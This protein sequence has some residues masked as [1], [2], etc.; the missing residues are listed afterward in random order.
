M[1]NIVISKH[2]ERQMLLRSAGKEEVF[3]T[4]LNGDVQKAKNNKLHSLLKFEFNDYSIVND[5]YYNSKTIDVIFVEEENE[6]VVITVKVYY[7]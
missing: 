6:I 1:K 3:E 2:A 7:H 5:K 4:I